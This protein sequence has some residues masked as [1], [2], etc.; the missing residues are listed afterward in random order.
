[1]EIA[2]STLSLLWGRLA[3]GFNTSDSLEAIKT[4]L[5][6]DYLTAHLKHEALALNRAIELSSEFRA[7]P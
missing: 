6:S 4:L 5:G 1:M 7:S 3:K 2:K